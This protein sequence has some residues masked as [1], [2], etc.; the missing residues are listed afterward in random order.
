MVG[1]HIDFNFNEN[2]PSSPNDFRV[3]A[4]E[5]K[6]IGMDLKYTYKVVVEAGGLNTVLFF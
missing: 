3:R 1:V 4:G 5:N 6:F 2:I